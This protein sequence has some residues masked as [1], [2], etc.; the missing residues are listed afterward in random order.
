MS[1][2][3]AAK[4]CVTLATVGIVMRFKEGRTFPVLFWYWF[5]DEA[6]RWY[7]DKVGVGNDT[8]DFGGIL[9]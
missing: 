1:D 4:K 5:D 9:F 7:L 2:A 6:G 3:L 8:G